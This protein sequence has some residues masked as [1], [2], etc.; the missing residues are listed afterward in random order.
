[1][2]ERSL[3]N[4]LERGGTD[5]SYIKEIPGKFPVYTFDPHPRCEARHVLCIRLSRLVSRD[6]PVNS[7]HEV[8]DDVDLSHK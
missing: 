3:V 4:G 7:T 1:M 8:L 6:Q 2:G 5:Y